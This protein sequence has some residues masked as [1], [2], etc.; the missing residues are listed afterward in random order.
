MKQR[1]AIYVLL[2]VLVTIIATIVHLYLDRCAWIEHGEEPLLWDWQEAIFN[3]RIAWA[4]T[5]Y[6]AVTN[7]FALAWLCRNSKSRMTRYLLLAWGTTWLP[8]ALISTAD[9][10]A[11]SAG[12][13][14]FPMSIYVMPIFALFCIAEAVLLLLFRFLITPGRKNNPLAE[15]IVSHAQSAQPSRSPRPELHS[16][17]E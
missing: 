1:L 8:V 15:Q 10:T 14:N 17:H 3:G 4:V 5:Q 12:P 2:L 7:A 11:S 16:T 9:V 13:F 6:I